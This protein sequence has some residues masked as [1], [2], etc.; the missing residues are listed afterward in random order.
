MRTKT[1]KIG[2][3]TLGNRVHVSDPCYETSCWCAGTLENVLPGQYNCKI[4]R[5]NDDCDEGEAEL[6]SRVK[7]LVICHEKYKCT[8]KEC[9]TIDVGV[10]SGQAGFYDFNYYVQQHQEGALRHCDEDWY[11]RVCNSTLK[12]FP[13]PHYISKKDYIRNAM[14]ESFIELPQIEAAE[15]ASTITIEQAQ[16]LRNTYLRAYCN[17]LKNSLAAWPTIQV[18]Y[19][20]TLDDRCCV[21]SSGYGD[22]GYNC[23]VARNSAGQIVAARIIFI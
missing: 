22:G 20:G 23:Y 1:N 6:F 14:G 15:A 12:T 5:C 3:I 4:V 2:I 21:S 11:E 18:G 17:Y 13:N 8:P 16:E 10:D 9:V 19:A 7:S